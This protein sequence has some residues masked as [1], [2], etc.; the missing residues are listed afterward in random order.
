MKIN[1]K[2]YDYVVSQPFDVQ[3]LENGGTIELHK[4]NES[5][6]IYAEYQPQGKL[7]VWTSKDGKNY[8]LLIEEGLYQVIRE[9][10][11][12]RCNQAWVN[13][14][15]NVEKGRKKIMLTLFLPIVIVVLGIAVAFMFLSQGWNQTTQLL[16]MGAILVV[17]IAGNVIVNKKIDNLINGEN[18]K[19]VDAIKGIVGHERFDEIMDNQ[20]AYYDK[21]YAVPDDTQVE[22]KEE[23]K[24]EA[25]ENKIEEVKEEKENE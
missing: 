10:H 19:A 21:L 14:W 15:D 3:N 9:L 5:E 6:A 17:F 20:R 25:E 8:R 11:V 1:K 2:L 4:L 13:F 22:N 24:E 18:K 12:K 7:S 16:V 23:V